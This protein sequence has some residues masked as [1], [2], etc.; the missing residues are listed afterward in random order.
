MARSV[1]LKNEA[2]FF[3]SSGASTLH[4]D[5]ENREKKTKTVGSEL[6]RARFQDPTTKRK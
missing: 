6:A 1:I 5:E 2:F 3:K 4:P